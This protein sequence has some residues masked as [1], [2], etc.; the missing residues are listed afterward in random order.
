M[1]AFFDVVSF[2]T[3]TG[4]IWVRFQDHL[5]TRAMSNILSS[6]YTNRLLR[7]GIVLAVKSAGFPTISV[8]IVQAESSKIAY[9]RLRWLDT[10]KCVTGTFKLP[11]YPLSR[12]CAKECTWRI[13]KRR[14]LFVCVLHNMSFEN[15]TNFSVDSTWASMIKVISLL[16]SLV[17]QIKIIG[18]CKEAGLAWFLRNLLRLWCELASPLCS[19]CTTSLTHMEDAQTYWPAIT[20]TQSI[21]QGSKAVVDQ[22]RIWKTMCIGIKAAYLFLSINQTP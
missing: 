3:E 6:L 1:L 19:L 8:S 17:A 20:A 13:L 16:R 11:P 4:S 15:T 9:V 14:M 18:A 21:Q 12:E 5:E 10:D 2:A 7:T 22:N